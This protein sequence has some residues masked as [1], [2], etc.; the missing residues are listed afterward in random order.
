MLR[1]DDLPRE[2]EIER[3]YYQHIA[4]PSA[5]GPTLHAESRVQTDLPRRVVAVRW[6]LC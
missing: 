6:C 2:S 1:Q 5:K 4:L 3:I